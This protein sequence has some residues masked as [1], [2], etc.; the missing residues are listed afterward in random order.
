MNGKKLPVVLLIVS[1]LIA[2]SGCLGRRSWVY[3]P[4]A[5]PSM[6][7]PIVKQTIAVPPFID[8]RPTLNDDGLAYAAIPGLPYG[9]QHL[10]APEGVGKHVQTGEWHFCPPEDFAKALAGELSISGMFEEAFY[11]YRPGEA[12]LV[13]QGRLRSTRY[14]GKSFMYA[15]SYYGMLA[16]F[17]GF[18]QY[19]SSNRVEVEFTLYDN[20]SGEALWTRAYERG[21]YNLSWY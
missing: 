19:S 1:A 14:N 16:W 11:T 5:V 12:D 13:L 2:L 17:I 7:P 10:E 4:R 21:I 3:N 6:S 20:G 9:W 8:E 18:P 15:F